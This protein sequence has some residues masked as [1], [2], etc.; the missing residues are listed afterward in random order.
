MATLRKLSSSRATFGS[1]ETERP[2]KKTSKQKLQPVIDL[3]ASSEEEAP[4]VRSVK[5]PLGARAPPQKTASWNDI[6]TSP[7]VAVVS[8]AKATKASTKSTTKTAAK[9]TTKPLTKTFQEKKYWRAE[10]DR[11]KQ[12]ESN[13][14]KAQYPRFHWA[15]VN[16][17]GNFRPPSK[18][19][20]TSDPDELRVAL[21]EI[22]A[23]GERVCS[24]D[25]EWEFDRKGAHRTAL[26][27]VG[28]LSTVVIFSVSQREQDGE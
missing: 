27:Q 21:E 24:L 19:I 2:V 11:K 10:L 8:K 15:N 9:S 6:F 7:P 4:P 5:G 16:R 12:E 14:L 22:Y 20:F 28:T 13:K 23:K 1:Y 17:K 26:V 18:R 3:S 25:L